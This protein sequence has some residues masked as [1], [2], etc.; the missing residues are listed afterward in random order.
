MV[1]KI[2]IVS[3]AVVAGLFLLSKTHLGSYCSTAWH[4]VSQSVGSAVP[5]EF[6]IERIRN[7]IAQL[8][9]EMRSQIKAIADEIVAVENLKKDVGDLRV[10]VSN[11][12]DGLLALRKEVTSGTKTVSFKGREMTADKAREKLQRDFDTYKR[13]DAGLKSKEALLEA[14]ENALSAAREQ[15]ASMR[16]KKEELT[17]A[18]AQLEAELKTLRVAETK[19]NIKLDDNKLGE[20]K[21][22]VKDLQDRVHASQVEHELVTQWKDGN[23]LP[24]TKKAQTAELTKEIDDYFGGAEVDVTA[25]NK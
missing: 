25:G 5:M 11:Q 15:L 17:V 8:D 4:K 24:A 3:L 12:K 14:K 7:E 20:I 6:E 18:V 16:A 21:K 13:A 9:P 23:D 19:S 1:K 22:A 2:V 10:S